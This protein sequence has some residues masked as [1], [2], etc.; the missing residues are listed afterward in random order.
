[1]KNEAAYK[2]RGRNFECKK[3]ETHENVESACNYKTL[4]GLISSLLN[5]F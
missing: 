1:M 3:H 2:L 5:L 4:L